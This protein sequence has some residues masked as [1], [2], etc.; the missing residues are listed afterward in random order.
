MIFKE[1]LG[2]LEILS[3]RLSFRRQLRSGPQPLPVS[4]PGMP[5]QYRPGL[6]W[7]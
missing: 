2:A 6:V 3:A 4:R 5:L 1:G 7:P